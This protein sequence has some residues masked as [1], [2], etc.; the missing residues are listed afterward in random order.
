MEIDEPADS[1]RHN[2]TFLTGSFDSAAAAEVYGI[3]KKNPAKVLTSL[4]KHVNFL[5]AASKME[6]Q[7]QRGQIEA[8][9]IGKKLRKKVSSAAGEKTSNF[10]AGEK[11]SNLRREEKKVKRFLSQKMKLI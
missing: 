8:L 1:T 6:L 9:E 5:P 3:L 4:S 10:A 2:Q 11:T 7:E